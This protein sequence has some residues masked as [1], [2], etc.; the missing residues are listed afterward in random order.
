[1]GRLLVVEDDPRLGETLCTELRA[2]GWAVSWAR[3]AHGARRQLAEPWEAILLDLGLP[4][5]SGL[6]L[7]QEVRATGSRV[8]VVVLTARVR[9]EDKVRA[10]DLGADDYVTKPF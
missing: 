3:D 9:G 1:M 7:L 6:D 5:A 10:L 8:P 4:D 2:A